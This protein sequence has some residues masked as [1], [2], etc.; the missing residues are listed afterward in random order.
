MPDEGWLGCAAH[1]LSGRKLLSGAP[2]SM[3]HNR[4]CWLPSDVS[5]TFCFRLLP[6]SRKTSTQL[7]DIMAF[8]I[9][10]SLVDTVN[11]SIPNKSKSSSLSPKRC[12]IIAPLDFDLFEIGRFFHHHIAQAMFHHRAKSPVKKS[13]YSNASESRM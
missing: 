1:R 5:S 4:E 7:V 2:V 11:G 9:S 13:R 10:S 12:F 6:G 8:V 3:E